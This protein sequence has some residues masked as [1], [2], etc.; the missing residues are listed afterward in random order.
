M[1]Y[2]VTAISAHRQWVWVCVCVCVCVKKCVWKRE[3]ERVRPPK[4]ISDIFIVSSSGVLKFSKVF[5]LDLNESAFLLFFFLLLTLAFTR[6]FTHTHT[7]THT[8]KNDLALTFFNLKEFIFHS[9]KYFYKFLQISRS[10]LRIVKGH[11]HDPWKEVIQ[12]KN[13]TK[14]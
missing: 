12:S 1:L 8:Q 6:T 2:K 9:K 10:L 3:R 4:K 11:F 7:H 5:F 14:F 13:W